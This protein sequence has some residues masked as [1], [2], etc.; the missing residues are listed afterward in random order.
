MLSFIY[1]VVYILVAKSVNM[2]LYNSFRPLCDKSTKSQD[3][4]RN[5]IEMKRALSQQQVHK[6]FKH[7]HQI[8]ISKVD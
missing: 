6:N 4:H 7:Q 3:I 5:V 2:L 1:I 8:H